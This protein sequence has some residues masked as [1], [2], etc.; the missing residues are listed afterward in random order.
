MSTYVLVHGAWGGSYG[1]TKFANLFFNFAILAIFIS[2]L[3]LLGLASYSTIQRTK[4]IGVR[5]IL[6][7]S[8]TRIVNMLS[9][10]F[11]KLVLIAF[12][13]AIP[14][15]WLGMNAWLRSFAYRTEITG[16]IFAMAGITA[17]LIAF[18]TISYQA[19]RAAL[20]N[21]VKSLRTE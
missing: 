18:F 9:L 3:G 4:E 20:A 7:A 16:W 13:I 2:C 19:I 5:K 15:G 17:L 1:W 10:D 12:V 8:A 21:P 14:I 11:I 6:G